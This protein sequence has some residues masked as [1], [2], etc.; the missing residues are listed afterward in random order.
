MPLK[1]V[2]AYP[3]A[4]ELKNPTLNYNLH[5]HL[6]GTR[7]ESLPRGPERRASTLGML[8]DYSTMVVLYP[9]AATQNEF[10]LHGIGLMNAGLF[11]RHAKHDRRDDDG[12]YPILPRAVRLQSLLENEHK[13]FTGVKS[14]KS[15][16]PSL[17]GASR[18]WKIRP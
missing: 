2:R 17:E 3:L 15:Q 7:R 13:L 8:P 1:A 16:F 4:Y 11:N 9:R 18:L 10:S 5:F 14:Q 12:H 6:L